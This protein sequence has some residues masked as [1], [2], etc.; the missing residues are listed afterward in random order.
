M[1]KKVITFLKLHPIILNLCWKILRAL[2]KFVAIFVPVQEKTMI[3]ASFGG[4]KFDDSPRAIYQE[5]CRR[6]YFEDWRLIWFFV[7]PNEFVIPRGEKKKIDT[8]FFFYSL[9]SSKVWIC[10]SSM[11]R[12][13]ELRRKNKTI[14]VETWHGTPLKRIG[15]DEKQN[16]IGG[17]WAVPGGSPDRYTIRCAQSEYDKGIFARIFN[18]DESSFLMCDLP[19]NDELVNYKYSKVTELRHKF[20]IPENKKVIL[21]MPTYR[22]YSIN[23]EDENYIALPIDWEKWRNRLGKRYC[24]LIRAHYVVT[25]KIN[26]NSDDFLIDVSDYPTLNDLY[27]MSDLLISDY[28]S[29]FFDFSILKRPMFCFAYDLLEYEK[30]RGLYLDLEKCLPCPVDTDEE[31][32]LYHILNIDEQDARKCVERFQKQYVPYPGK[33]CKVVVDTIEER[34]MQSCI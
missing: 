26:I 8:F 34:L 28:S 10:N 18:A 7:N 13:I 27:I 2:M 29:S 25:Q 20:K 12:G 21:Y 15:G 24:L 4:R 5:V 22:E 23:K 14:V 11:D 32:L 31:S 6:K 33:A 17:K 30:K 3:F 9:L 16:S 19:R 1:R